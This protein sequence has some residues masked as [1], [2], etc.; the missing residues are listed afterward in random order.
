MSKL[1]Y[2]VILLAAVLAL[3]AACDETEPAPTPTPLPSPTPAPT[4]TAVPSPT[5][6]PP[7]PTPAPAPVAVPDGVDL[8]KLMADAMAALSASD[9]FHYDVN[10]TV[11]ANLAGFALDIPLTAVGDFQPPDR[12]QTTMSVSLGFAS[13]D[14]ETITIGET[15]YVK[16]PVSG[17][18]GIGDSQLSLFSDPGVLVFGYLP[19]EESLAAVGIETLDGIVTM[20]LTGVAMGA[21]IGAPDAEATVDLWIGQEDGRIYKLVVVGSIPVE[22]LG[23]EFAQAGAAGDL[24]LDATVVFSDYGKPVDI[25]APEVSSSS[26]G[27]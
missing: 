4:A 3:S 24:A 6:L 17:E 9:P 25:R 13:I 14:S 26:P 21:A 1:S 27:M 15:T 18:W 22:A 12:A 19:S 11:S 10:A 23:E 5:S 7:T 20:H 2:L 8:S 16:D